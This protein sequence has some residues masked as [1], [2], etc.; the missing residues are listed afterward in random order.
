MFALI[1]SK[2]QASLLYIYVSVTLIFSQTV[3]TQA[4]IQY[5]WV[6]FMQSV[7]EKCLFILF[8]AMYSA[9]KASHDIRLLYS[10]Q[11]KE[12]HLAKNYLIEL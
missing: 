9:E 3:H 4:A 5:F 8:H 11:T 10:G 2:A 7:I 6:I 1:S 12:K